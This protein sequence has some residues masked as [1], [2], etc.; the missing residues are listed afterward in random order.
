MNRRHSN[1]V[2]AYMAMGTLMAL[3]TLSSC[4]GYDLGDE[5]PSWLGSSIYAYLDDGNYT[6]TVRL[7]NDLNY[8]TVLNTTGS[9]TLFVADD[10]AFNRF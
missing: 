8:G 7:I 3:S 4:D 2:M 10:D 1:R 5:D 9:K 6:N